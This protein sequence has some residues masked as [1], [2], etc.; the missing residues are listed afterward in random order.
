MKLSKEVKVGILTVVAIALF[1]FGYSYLKGSNLLEDNRVYYAVYDN[2]EG[3]TKSAPV[4][5]NGL[6]VGNIDDIKFLDDSGRL[7]V[8]FH[9][10]GEFSFS[11]ESTASVYSTS[12]IGGKALAIVPNFESTAIVAKS[13]DTLKSKLDKGLQGEVMDQFIPLKDKIEH[14]VVS[15]DSVL[16]AVNKTLNP[17][18]RAAITSSLE[19]L[20]KTL[21]EFKA[22]SRNA[23]TLL[24]DNKESLG[25]T[26]KNLDVTTENFAKISDT[27]AQ[28]EI[29]GTVKQLE[30]TI[31]KF[32][33]VLDKVSNGE[34]SLGKLMTD[35]KLYTNLE[36]ATEQAADL[37]QDMKLNPKRYV[38]F[39][40]FGKRP[41]PY[42]E[43]EDPTK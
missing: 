14:M 28:V 4:T 19:E 13:G 15:A 43:P 8:K 25:R 12:L 34:G 6:R 24:A 29:A 9:V 20:N 21:V 40:V 32:N 37:L 7:I 26:I 38:H 33:T 27:L 3:L 11:S 39:S 31:G 5:I 1:I 23:N 42:E 30:E 16:V 17:D 41:G 36:R 35:D 18:A 2:V 22:L 10:N